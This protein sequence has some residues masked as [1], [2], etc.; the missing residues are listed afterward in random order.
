MREFAWHEILPDAIQKK[1]GCVHITA[2]IAACVL[3]L[4]RW[5]RGINSQKS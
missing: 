2:N 1:C 3:M 4:P 5:K